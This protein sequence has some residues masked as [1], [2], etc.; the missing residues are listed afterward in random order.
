MVVMP[1]SPIQA[2]GLLLSSIRRNDPVIFLEPKRL[3]RISEEE[4]LE[5]D[6]MIDLIKGEKIREGVI[7]FI[8][9][10]SIRSI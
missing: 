2:K 8:F 9:F 10:N 5:E 7:I 6:Y 1:R 3:Y 4:V